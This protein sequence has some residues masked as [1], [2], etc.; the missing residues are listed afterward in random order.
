LA[1]NKVSGT[2]ILNSESGRNKFLIQNDQTTHEMFPIT[3]LEQEL[4]ALGTLLRYFERELN[5]EVRNLNL[6]ELTNVK[7]SEANMP[8]FVFESSE[9]NLPE[10]FDNGFS[11]E[12]ADKL[13][14]VFETFDIEGVPYF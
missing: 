4:T 8:F 3:I 2:I 13:N 7:V 14:N 12:Y 5:I 9:V 6:I 10:T 11:W 1:A